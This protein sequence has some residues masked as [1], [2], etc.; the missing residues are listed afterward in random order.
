VSANLQF[1][2]FALEPCFEPEIQWI[3]AREFLQKPMACIVSGTGMASARIS[4]SDDE[5]DLGHSENT[6]NTE[7][8][9]KTTGPVIADRQL[10]FGL[11]FR[12]VRVVS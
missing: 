4:Q 1:S 9:S 3:A 6:D 12:R 7:A 8:K 10:L 11:L 2:E 5:D